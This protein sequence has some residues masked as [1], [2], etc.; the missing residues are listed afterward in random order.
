MVPPARHARTCSAIAPHSNRVSA[1]RR[2]PFPGNGKSGARDWG[3]IRPPNRTP[4]V[5]EIEP[6]VQI[7]RQLRAFLNRYRNSPQTEEC[8]VV[9]AVH[10]QPVS[11]CN[12][13]EMQGEFGEMQTP[14]ITDRRMLI[15]GL[16]IHLSW[17]C[18]RFWRRT[19]TR[20]A[21]LPL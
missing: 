16:I 21:N 20:S 8:V 9:D 12:F 7:P 11:P 17:S 4:A 13:G 15:V 2:S 6:V 1:E 14:R 5:S 19:S 10:H 3:P 18:K